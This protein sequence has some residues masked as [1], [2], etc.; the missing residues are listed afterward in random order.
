MK[1]VRPLDSTLDCNDLVSSLGGFSRL[2][3]LDALQGTRVRAMNLSVVW[4]FQTL[5]EIKNR[6]LVL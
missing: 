2:L 4:F 5:M 3:L 6:R 1:P